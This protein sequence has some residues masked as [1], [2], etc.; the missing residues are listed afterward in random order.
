M[1]V[2]LGEALKTYRDLIAEY[3]NFSYILLAMTII[4]VLLWVNR[5]TST[6]YYFTWGIFF[7]LIVMTI[8]FR[9][10]ELLEHID[11]IFQADFYQNLY[12]YHWNMILCFY[13]L[14]SQLSSRRI[15][16]VASAFCFLFF[17]A[18]STNAVFQFFISDYVGNSSLL[19]LGNTYPM[20]TVGNL[21]S[22]AFYL[23]ILISHLFYKSSDTPRYK[24]YFDK[25]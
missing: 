7:L 10:M 20:I 24:H 16:E 19:V 4:G 11:T 5:K 13:L 21:L 14:H 25:Q 3:S 22:F 15:N 12:F 17:I 2:T 6:T 1:G 23:L 9:R 18:L 8:Y